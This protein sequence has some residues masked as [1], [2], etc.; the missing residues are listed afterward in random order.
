[1]LAGG[2]SFPEWDIVAT[3]RHGYPY[4]SGPAGRVS[5]DGR[6][7]HGREAA[8]LREMI[9]GPAKSVLEAEEPPARI[10]TPRHL[11]L[12]LPREDSHPAQERQ[13]TGHFAAR[14]DPRR[15][16]DDLHVVDYHPCATS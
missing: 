4:T 10:F 3:Q 9:R 2:T 1:M 11:G 13:A 5:L 6:S 8:L 12:V 16:V 7:E 14:V 15:T